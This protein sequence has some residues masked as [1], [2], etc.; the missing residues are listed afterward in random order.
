[1]IR[2]ILDYNG[3]VVGQLE[4][5]D[6]TPEQVWQEKLAFFALPPKV[7]TLEELVANKIEQYEK[8]APEL[9]RELKRDNT[10]AGITTQQSA[11]MFAD[12]LDVIIMIREGAF[13]TALH[14][15]QQKQPSGFV[16]QERLD[17]WIAKIKAW[18]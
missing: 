10:L 12:Y 8:V 11:Q 5:P 14:T 6:D 1:M 2:D 15:L 4:L 7:A 3:N 9:L 17:G 16:T 13:P 18:M